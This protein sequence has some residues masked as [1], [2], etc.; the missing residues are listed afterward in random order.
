MPAAPFG[1]ERLML[2]SLALVLSL[3]ACQEPDAATAPSM[4]QV[5]LPTDTTLTASRDGYVTSKHPNRNGGGK[6]SMDVAQPLRSLVAFDQA[7]IA[8][9]VGTGTLTS[10]TLRLTIGRVAENWGPSGRTIDVH[11]VTVPWTEAGET[12]N[13]AIDAIPS[14]STKECAGATEW[15]MGSTTAPPW[16]SPRTAQALVTTATTGTLEFDVTADVRAFLAGTPNE[17]WLLKKTDEDKQG[18]IVFLTKEGGAAPALVLAVV[19]QPPDTSRPPVPTTGGLNF[20]RDTALVVAVPG[21]TITLFFRSIFRVRF[22]DSTSGTTIRVFLQETGGEIIGG[23]PASAVYVI[24]FPDPG[25]SYEAFDSLKARL[26][27]TPGVSFAAPAARRSGS[28]VQSRY[29]NDGSAATRAA[30]LG[31][32]TP[33]TRPRLEIRAP[34]AWG[35]ETGAYGGAVPSV[36]VVDYYLDESFAYDGLQVTRIEPD[37]QHVALEATDLLGNPKHHSH[38]TGVSGILL[39]PGDDSEGLAG[40]IWNARFTFFSLTR[41]AKIPEDLPAYLAYYILPAASERGVR[42]LVSSVFLGASDS[43]VVE[44]LEMAIANFT[45]AGGLFIQATGN[46]GVRYSPQALLAVTGS[47]NLGLI[48]AV[49]SLLQFNPSARHGLLLVGGTD[50]SGEFWKVAPGEGSNFFDGITEI[51]APATNILTLAVAGDVGPG[52]GGGRQTQDGTSLSA[53]FV[54]GV[55]AQLLAMDSTLTN[56]ELKDYLI[57]GSR[58]DRE[59]P[60]TGGWTPAPNPGAPDAAVR[61]LDAYGSLKLLSYERPGTPLCGLTITNLGTQWYQTQSVIHRQG[62]QELVEVAGQ[63]VAFTSIAQGGRLAAAGTEKYRLSGGQWVGA[64]SGGD[65]AIV[66]LERDT[67]YLRPVTTSGPLW[68]RTDLR[69]RIGSPD[70]SGVV[71]ALNLTEDFQV[72]LEGAQYYWASAQYTPELVSVSPTGD[73]VYLEFTGVFN[74]DCNARPSESWEYRSLIPLRGGQATELSTRHTAVLDCTSN[75]PYPM[76]ITSTAAAGGRIAWKGDGQEFYYGRE[77]YDAET[78]L[79]RWTVAGG[80]GPMGT[81][82]AVGLLTFDAL[83]WSQEGGRLLSREQYLAYDPPGDCRERIRASANP[84]VMPVDKKVGDFYTSCPD[85]PLTA[86]R[87]ATAAGFRATPAG[88]PKPAINRRYPLGI[89]RTMRPN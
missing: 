86:A 88:K 41:G 49:G 56:A 70:A 75:P 18:R 8:G 61:Q 4:S 32:P 50:D 30:W 23:L 31:T 53:P 74:D 58:V 10:A 42:V 80:V 65:D 26:N 72:N 22:D 28:E 34:L 19:A 13:C 21:D 37:S 14:N 73:W 85:I 62:T 6:D 2:L 36:G 79:E 59:D 35:C 12:Y 7:A 5:L 46:Q 87:L 29:P 43:A 51:L 25:N 3:G 64:G 63:P 55:A 24:R 9:A 16:A 1:P 33:Y 54:G 84:S 89:P 45:A 27:S 20:P 39:G 68:T 38:G 66:F 60:E 76:S 81:D 15:D 57:R 69:V 83:V 17:G 67:A 71:D 11:R 82:P 77:Y 44:E 47:P 48:Q 52:I 40:M 78:R